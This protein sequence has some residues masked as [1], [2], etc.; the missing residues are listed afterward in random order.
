MIPWWEYAR[1]GTWGNREGRVGS[2]T[3]SGGVWSSFT[4]ICHRSQGATH[5]PLAVVDGEHV[6]SCP[7][8]D[9]HPTGCSNQETHPCNLLN[10]GRDTHTY[11]RDQMMMPFIQPGG[12]LSEIRGRWSCSVR[13]DPG[14]AALLKMERLEASG[15]TPKRKLPA[16]L[17]EGILRL[18]RQ[19][20]GPII[21]PTKECSLRRGPT[22]WQQFFQEMASSAGLLDSNVHEVQDEWTGQKD[23][24]ATHQVA[25]SSL[26]DICFFWLVPPNESPKIMGLEGIHYPEVLKWQASQSFCPWC[27][28]EGQNE[29]TVANHLCTM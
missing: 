19:P 16:G 10:H 3:P 5:V 26:R 24:L 7:F 2:P 8:G 6:L 22:I 28:K 12:G 9:Y 18:S 23:L 20:G 21:Q 13:D 27:G 11:N 29:G 1:L 4:S 15:K 25:K 17:F 14:G